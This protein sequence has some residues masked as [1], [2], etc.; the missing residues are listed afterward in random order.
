MISKQTNYSSPCIKT[1]KS[2]F[3]RIVKISVKVEVQV[4]DLQN[5]TTAPLHI[6]TS[7]CIPFLCIFVSKL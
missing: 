2:K 1:G 5:Y 6:P 3:M 4:L 7:Y